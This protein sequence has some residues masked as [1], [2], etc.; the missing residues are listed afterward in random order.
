MTKMNKRGF[1]FKGKKIDLDI[2][3]YGMLIILIVITL[4]FQ[5][6]TNGVLL[7]P[8]NISKLIMQ[9]GYI[10]ILAIGMLPV[11]LTGNID[12]SVG[13]IMA[14]VGAVTSKM[15]IGE[16]VYPV[17]IA[18]LAG[19]LTGLI[20]GAWNGYWVAY[21]KIPAFIVTLSSMLLFRGLTLVITKGK[22]LGPYPESYQSI[23]QTYLPDLP[24]T[25]SMHLTSLIIGLIIII[26]YLILSIQKR[27]KQIQYGIKV[28][29]INLF[30]V[31]LILISFIIGFSAYWLTRFNGMPLI[32][33]ILGILVV[34]FSFVTQKTIIGRHVYALGG[35]E[36]ATELSGV[37]TNLVKFITF[38]NMGVLAAF[39][40]I[41]YSARI[42]CASPTAGDGFELDAIAA[43]YIGGASAAG[44]VGTI[45]GAMIGGLVMGILNNGMSIMGVGVDWQKTVKGLVL[46]AA[47][48]LDKYNQSKKK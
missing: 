6:Q 11:I 10:L 4:F 42:N 26:A 2:R 22:T 38:A 41:V 46:L 8:M 47:V 18:I 40:G 31:K 19:L 29:N 15:L 44:G 17:W 12:L 27:K 20:I 3:N 5:W 7:V 45:G 13:S 30:A 24:G 23:A 35:N 21:I 33:V 36:K 39:A 16:N 37:N 32:L 14:I 48:I 34:L 43:C 9:N 25:E 1:S 28:M